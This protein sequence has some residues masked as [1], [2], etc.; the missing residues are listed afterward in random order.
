MTYRKCLCSLSLVLY[1]HYDVKPVIL[2]K[3]NIAHALCHVTCMYGARNN[4]KFGNLD[5]DLP[6]FTIHFSGGYDDD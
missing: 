3:T 2:T 4:Q 5:P 1:R 6:V